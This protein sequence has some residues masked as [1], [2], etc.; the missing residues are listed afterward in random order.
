MARWMARAYLAPLSDCIWLFLPPGIQAKSETWLEQNHATPIPD[1]LTEKQ[2]ALLEKI[3]ARGPLK[4]TQ[5]EAHENGAADALV[6]RGLLNKSARV[7][8]P[9]AK[10]RIVDQARLVVDAATAREK[11]GAL[12]P[13]DR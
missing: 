4:T 6:R 1:D 13:P 8:P 10:P 11:I 12:V 5:L 2:R 7:R 3:S 9:A